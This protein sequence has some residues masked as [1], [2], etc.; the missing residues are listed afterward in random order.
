MTLQELGSA[1][2]FAGAVAVFISLIYVAMQIRRNTRAVMAS[3]EHSV[4]QAWNELNVRFAESDTAGLLL[5]GGKS[6]SELNL[7]DRFRFTLLMRSFMNVHFDAWRQ[8]QY[9]QISADFWKLNCSTLARELARPGI[10]A[11]WE[12]NRQGYLPAFQSEVD[13]LLVARQGAA[14]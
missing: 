10:R 8:V 4:V 12:A 6:Y 7:E 9:G 14:S 13:S 5:R 11:W 1:G 2:E 3:T